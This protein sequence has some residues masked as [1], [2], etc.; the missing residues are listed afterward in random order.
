MSIPYIRDFYKPPVNRLNG[1]QRSSKT[2]PT[3]ITHRYHYSLSLLHLY[4]PLFYNWRSRTQTPTPFIHSHWHSQLKESTHRPLLGVERWWYRLSPD[5][6]KVLSWPVHWL[7]PIAEISVWIGRFESSPGPTL[8]EGVRKGRTTGGRRVHV[9][10]D[11]R[12]R[13]CGSCLCVKTWILKSGRVSFWTQLYLWHS[14]TS[15]SSLLGKI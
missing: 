4:L 12:E 5:L 7:P 8:N 14:F 11:T 3:P 2:R 9:S 10:V 6:I 15:P 13:V 1:R